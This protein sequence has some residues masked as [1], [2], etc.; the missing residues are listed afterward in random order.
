MDFFFQN[1]FQT[2]EPVKSHTIIAIAHVRR[3][4]AMNHTHVADEL[5]LF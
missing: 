1:A 4:W 5:M 2:S 3:H